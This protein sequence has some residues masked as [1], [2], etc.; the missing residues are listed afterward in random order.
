MKNSFFEDQCPFSVSDNGKVNAISYIMHFDGATTRRSCIPGFKVTDLKVPFHIFLMNVSD[1]DISWNI[2]VEGEN[3]VMRMGPGQIFFDP[4]DR[5]FSRYTADCYE[6]LLLLLTPEKMLS[7][8]HAT[9]D[10]VTFEPVYNIWDPHLELPLKV[11][12]SEVQTGNLNG[13]EYIDHNISLIAL[14]F[15]SNYT[16]NSSQ[17][18]V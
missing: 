17:N 7:T 9:P 11:L 5:P 18:L 15:V 3:Q 10:T 12:L 13:E 16:K 4:A 8:I 1:R 14:H 6:F 2:Q